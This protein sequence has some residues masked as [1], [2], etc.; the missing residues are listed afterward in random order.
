[1]K[2]MIFFVNSEYKII[3]QEICSMYWLS[4]YLIFLKTN[5][6]NFYT[7]LSISIKIDVLV[8]FVNS[9]FIYRKSNYICSEYKQDLHLK[10]LI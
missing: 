4:E 8:N 6:L 10:T 9:L 3:H 7:I 5:Y 2:Y 1:M